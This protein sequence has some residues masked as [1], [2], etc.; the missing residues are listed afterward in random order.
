[1]ADSTALPTEWLVRPMNLLVSG[2]PRPTVNLVGLGLAGQ[3]ADSFLT[4][5]VRDPFDPPSPD[6]RQAFSRLPRPLRF[7][8]RRPEE[9]KPEDADANL[10]LWTLLPRSEGDPA[11]RGVESLRLPLLVREIL[12][13]VV[14]GSSPTLLFVANIDRLSDFYPE[15]TESTASW[16]RLLADE[17]V[18]LLATWSGPDRSDFAA[19]ESVLSV[20][21]PSPTAGTGTVKVLRFAPETAGWAPGS[22]R[23]LRDL[24]GSRSLDGL[25]AP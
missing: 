17:N 14:R 24:P 10:A 12:Q 23:P 3:L 15:R 19:F 7:V 22:E 6:E 21:G 4:I 5:E 25:D 1:M 8:V 11:P 13:R 20:V 16:L 2:H 18:S 9:L